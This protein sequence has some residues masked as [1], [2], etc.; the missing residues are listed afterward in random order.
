MFWLHEEDLPPG[1]GSRPFC[2][3]HLAYL[4]VFLA[5]SVCYGLLYRRLDG[6]RRK[7]ADRILGCV[8]FF[9][10]LC[11][12]GI[13]ALIGRFGRFT[14]PIHV[15]SLMVSVILIHAWTTDA[16]P[17][18]FAAIFH[19]FL[20]AVIFHPGILGT[21]AALLLPDWLAYPFW[22]YLSISG[23]L[24]HGFVSVYGSSVIVR[25]AEAKQPRE[26]LL[27][28]LR[29]SARFLLAGGVLMYF[30]DRA[31]GTNYWFMAGPSAESPF[32]RAYERGGFV[33]YLL[34]LAL[35]AIAATAVWYGLRYLLVC[36]RRSKARHSTT[37][38]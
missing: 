17:G 2:P 19:R 5:L 27:R 4:G 36:G 23:F 20:G 13:T 11:E 14:L 10:G 12:Y 7:T 25:C 6:K 28:D 34:A 9:F 22:N 38:R 31:T 18:S 35:A 16:Q 8:V 1:V 29:S 32:L 37:A 24:A 26:G 33:G 15:C 3:T 21:W 30:F